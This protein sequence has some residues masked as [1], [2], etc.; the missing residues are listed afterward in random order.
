MVGDSAADDEEAE[1]DED[2]GKTEERLVQEDVS[3]VGH[4]QLIEDIGLNAEG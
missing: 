2:D 1:G 3:D 4:E